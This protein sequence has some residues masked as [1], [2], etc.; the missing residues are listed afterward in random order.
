MK[1]VIC[2]ELSSWCI[3]VCGWLRAHG[4]QPAVVKAFKDA[5]ITGTMLLDLTLQ[6]LI[7]ATLAVTSLIVLLKYSTT[8]WLYVG[9][10]ALE[11]KVCMRGSNGH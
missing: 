2:A 8:S 7:G 4:V 1:K 10:H 5:S 11:S 6:D 3:Q 9:I